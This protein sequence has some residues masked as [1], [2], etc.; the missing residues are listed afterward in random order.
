MWLVVRQHTADKQKTI[1]EAH[2]VKS[3]F[4]VLNAVANEKTLQMQA[5]LKSCSARQYAPVV[6]P[7]RL[8]AQV[9]LALLR[10]Q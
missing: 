9:M 4:L 3:F 8:R 1:K 2:V 5:S 7:S 10:A 6:W